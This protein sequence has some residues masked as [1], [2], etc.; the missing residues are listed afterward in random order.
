MQ[1]KAKRWL[2]VGL[3]GA[4]MALMSG[5]VNVE[6]G[7]TINSDGTVHDKVSMALDPAMQSVLG[8]QNPFD[9]AK[10]SY[11]NAHYEVK[12]NATGFEAEKNY[13]S[14]FDLAKKGPVLYNPSE[15]DKGV[16]YKEGIFFDTYELDLLV[17][18]GPQEVITNPATQA[19]MQSSKIEYQI[20]LPYP[21]D[22]GKAHSISSDNRHLTWDM[23]PAIFEGKDVPIQVKFR[24]FHENRT[25]LLCVADAVLLVAG[26]GMFA[27]GFS[28]LKRSTSAKK[29][30]V[31]GVIWT[32]MAVGLAAFGYHMYT[33]VPTL[34]AAD[35]ISNHSGNRLGELLK[36]VDQGKIAASAN[37]NTQANTNQ[38]AAAATTQGGTQDPNVMRAYEHF[39]SAERY[40]KKMADDINSN[41]L[42]S[43]NYNPARA[44]AYASHVAMGDSTFWKLD[45]KARKEAAELD[46][47][48]LERLRAMLDGLQGNTAR[49]AEGSRLYDEFQVKFAQFKAEHNIP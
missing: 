7:V 5:C 20:N 49:Y 38:P 47:I 2:T 48:Q 39:L 34:T 33:T 1:L 6:S 4:C 9:D 21:A 15:E 19:L 31:T 29:Y 32:G 25:L 13:N 35:N 3:L 40:L 23:R 14:F 17:P 36:D 18:K 22:D 24:V 42:N 28:K 30:M 12:E 45:E 43:S 16:R 26:I 46:Y 41:R 37:T 10:E 27:F 8:N 11:K 44:E